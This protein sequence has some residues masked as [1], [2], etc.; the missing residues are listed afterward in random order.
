VFTARYALSPYIKQIRFVFKGLKRRAA[1]FLGCNTTTIFLFLVTSSRLSFISP[2]SPYLPSLLSLFPS[3]SQLHR[4]TDVCSSLHRMSTVLLPGNQ[5]A[6]FGVLL[7]ARSSRL[8][9]LTVQI[10]LGKRAAGIL[11]AGVINRPQ[12]S[13]PWVASADRTEC[14]TSTA[15][16]EITSLKRTSYWVT[17]IQ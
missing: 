12:M 16:A 7:V 6:V 1:E 17:K 9:W 4:A 13:Q 14:P 10:K 2:L 3:G 11:G 8:S 5:E 15:E